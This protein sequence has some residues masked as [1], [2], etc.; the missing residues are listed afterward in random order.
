MGLARFP[1]L[2]L[3][4][5]LASPAM[6]SAFWTHTLDTQ[7]ALLRLLI[8]VP[9][10]AVMLAIV[11]AVTRDYRRENKEKRPAVEPAIQAEVVTGEPLERRRTDRE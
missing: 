4:A 1:T 8:A 3:A 5:L 7:T 2:F 10:A 6:Y 11:R 9:V